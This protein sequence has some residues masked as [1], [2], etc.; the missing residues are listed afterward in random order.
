MEEREETFY[1]ITIPSTGEKFK[2]SQ[3]AYER[4]AANMFRQAP[5]AQVTRV[6][7]TSADDNDIN[8]R[9]QFQVLMDNGN[10][11]TLSAE[12]Y[13]RFKDKMWQEFPEAKVYKVSDI[14]WQRN[15]PSREEARKRLEEFDATNGEF[16]KKYEFADEQISGIDPMERSLL[17]HPQYKFWAENSSSYRA[18]QEKRNELRQA[19]YSNPNT[20]REMKEGAEVARI[21]EEDYRKKAES[22][23]GYEKKEFERA[24]KLM[25][26]V[27]KAYEA[28][29]NKDGKS[30][31]AKYWQ[32]AG[33][34]GD[35]DIWFAGARK[36]FRDLNLADIR[37][38]IE[39]LE[40][41]KGDAITETDYD[42]VITEGEKALLKS[43]AYL[44]E[45]QAERSTSDGKLAPFSTAYTAG[46][47][48][49]QSIPFMLEFLLSEGMGSAIAKGVRFLPETWAVSRGLVNSG[50]ALTRWIGKNLLSERSLLLAREAGKKIPT[51]AEAFNAGSKVGKALNLADD[52][53]VRP[54]VKG[55]WHTATQP[56]IWATYAENLNSTNDNN[57]LMGKWEAFG[58]AFW[59]NL[60]ENWSESVGSVLDKGTGWLGGKIL[61]TSGSLG[62]TSFGRFTRWMLEN[63]GTKTL[64]DAGFNGLLGEMAEEWIG[65]AVRVW[66][67]EMTGR[68]F[69]EFANWNQQLE[70]A[71]SFAPM[72]IIGLGTSTIA[73]ARRSKLYRQQAEDSK[74][75]LPKYGASDEDL[76]RI[77]NTR[78]DTPEDIAQ[79]LAPYAAKMFDAKE[80]GDKSAVE[81][82]KKLMQLSQSLGEN[83]IATQMEE[84]RKQVDRRQA[85]LEIAD[86]LGRDFVQTDEKGNKTVTRVQAPDGR[87]GY[88]VGK[89]DQSGEAA[90]LWDDGSTGFS[91]VSDDR[92]LT[93]ID[94]V[95]VSHI[96]SVQSEDEYLDGYIAEKKSAAQ[97]QR[98]EQEEKQN[99]MNLAAQLQPGAAIPMG[100]VEN[101]V[102]GT[103]IEAQADGVVVQSEDG[104]TSKISFEEAASRLGMPLRAKTDEQ[105]TAEILEA[106]DR[107][108]SK[109][110][111]LSD[112]INQGVRI[113]VIDGY[114]AVSF[115]APETQEDGSYRYPVIV[116]AANT[117]GS[118]VL[119]GRQVQSDD[120]GETGRIYLTEQEMDRLASML[121][122][123][124]KA[125][126]Y[127]EKIAA[128]TPLEVSIPNGE[129]NGS[130]TATINFT[131][132]DVEDGQ[133]MIYG[134]DAQGN[135]V[136]VTEDMVSNLPGVLA[137][138]EETPV[139][140]DE[141]VAPGEEEKMDDVNPLADYMRT[142]S[143]TGELEVDSDKLWNEN[144]DK[145]CEWNDTDNT[146]PYKVSTKDKLKYAIGELDK[147]I[148]KLAKT[149]KEGN[150]KGMEG[151]KKDELR[152]DIDALSKRR[153]ELQSLAERYQEQK[154]ETQA[155]AEANA[156]SAENTEEN[157]EK[158]MSFAERERALGDYL[159]FKD[160]VLRS[161]AMLSH[162]IMWSGSKDGV[163]KGLGSHLGFDSKSKER[164][165]RFWLLGNEK[166]AYP[167]EVAE[168]LQEAYAGEFGVA[169]EDAP[170]MGGQSALD[171]LL[172]VILENPTRTSML[173]S[174]ER[175]HREVEDKSSEYQR[176]FSAYV[177][178]LAAKYGLDAEFAADAVLGRAEDMGM[179]IEA[180][181]QEEVQ[182]MAWQ[183]SEEYLVEK[184]EYI[185]TEAARI[186]KFAEEDLEREQYDRETETTQATAGQTRQGEGAQTAATRSE[187]VVPGE[188]EVRQTSPSDGREGNVAGRDIAGQEQIYSEPASSVRESPAGAREEQ[189]EVEDLPSGEDMPEFGPFGRIFREYVGKA[190]EAI[191]ALIQNQ[192]GEAI[193]ALS[194]PQI[195]SID[196][197]WGEAGTGKSDGFGLAK[198]IKYHPEVVENLQE[199]LDDMVVVSRTENRVQL[200]SERYK[201]TVRLTWD[202]QRKTW[203]LTAFEKKNSALDNT[204]DTGETSNGSE[205]ND[206]ATPQDTVSSDKDSENSSKASESEEN[207]Q[208]LAAAL[209]RQ[210]NEIEE[211]INEKIRNRENYLGR[212][213]LYD[214][215]RRL[216]TQLEQLLG[217]LNEK[218]LADLEA[219]E[220]ESI[221]SSISEFKKKDAARRLRSR[222]SALVAKAQQFV[223]TKAKAIGSKLNLGDYLAPK[224]DA[225]VLM[226][227]VFHDGGYAV[228]SDTQILIADKASYEEKNEG[229]IIGRDG[230]PI[231]GKYPKWRELLPDF[232]AINKQW[233]DFGKLRDFIASAR[234]AIE[235][236][237]EQRKASGDTKASKAKYLKNTFAKVILNLGKNEAIAFKLDHLSNF[238]DFAERIGAKELYYSDEKRAIFVKTGKGIGMLMPVQLDWT[239][240]EASERAEF[241]SDNY[242]Y[243]YGENEYQKQG[244]A[245]ESSEEN[246]QLTAAQKNVLGWLD[247]KS[248]EQVEREYEEK[249]KAEEKALEESEKTRKK[250]E[251]RI[252]KWKKILGDVFEVH[253]DIST[254]TDK[255]AIREIEEDGSQV[256]GWYDP[257]TG[258]AH[259]YIP[260]I[261][262]DENP[263][264]RVDKT[265]LHEC[266]AHKGVRGIFKT[267]EQL[268]DFFDK[269]WKMMENY[270]WGGVPAREHFLGYV[271]G[272][273]TFATEQE[274]QRAAAD[275]F[276]AHCAEADEAVIKEM[277]SNFWT[278]LLDFIKDIFKA[279]A[280]MDIFEEEG[281]NP[282]ADII[283]QS[284]SEFVK[285]RRESEAKQREE[286][287]RQETKEDVLAA[288]D[289]E[290]TKATSTRKAQDNP[291]IAV[292]QTQE[293]YEDFGE[294]IGMARKDTAVSGIKRGDADGRPSWAKKYNTVNVR[295]LSDEEM[296]QRQRLYLGYHSKNFDEVISN[297]S[298][299][300]DFN[301]PF[302]GFWDEEKKTAFGTRTIRH[303]ITG[304]GGKPIIF[305]S[306]AQFEATMPVFE[307]SRSG[308]RVIA[309]KEGKFRIAKQASNGKYVEYAEF[310]SREDA[311]AYL[312]SPEGATD[313]LNRKRE[314]YELPALEELTRNGMPDYRN[315]KNVTP[316]D[317]Q[318]AF[319]FRGGEF[320]N[321]LNAE[322]RQQFLNYAYDALMDLASILHIS[323][324]ALSLGGE[325][326]IAFGARGKQGARAHYEPT[327]AVINLTKMNGAGS[328]AHEWAHALDNYF[329]MMD[330]RQERIRD[331]KQGDQNDHYLSRE[332]SYQ[333]GAREEVRNAFKEVMDV[334]THK[335]EVR[336]IVEEKEREQ[337]DKRRNW[338]KREVEYVR[339][340]LEMGRT[341]YEY[342][343]KTKQ[344]E[345]VK[346][347]MTEEQLAEFDSLVARLETD[348]T[349]KYDW[350]YTR[351]Q[352]RGQGEVADK[353]RELIKE[354]MPDRKADNP[355][356]D[357][358]H[359]IALTRKQ[360]ERL[361][362]AKDG[363]TETLRVKTDM[364][365]SSEWFDRGRAGSY[366]AKPLEM[367]ARAFET[368][369]AGEMKAGVQT[370]D[371]LTYEKSPLYMA[372]W[373]KSPYPMGAER[374]AAK[375]AFDK[376]FQTIQEK[377][378]EKTGRQVL[379]SRKTVTIPSTSEKKRITGTID[380]VLAFVQG[381]SVKEA[382]EFRLAEE[383]KRKE[384]AAEIYGR[385]LNNQFDSVTLR[386]IN[387]YIDNGTPKNPYGRRISKRL[388]QEVERG[389]YEGAR[390][391]A[392]DALLSRISEGAV[393]P[394]RRNSPSERRRIAQA[395]NVA[396]KGWAIAAGNW[397]TDLKQFTDQDKPFASGSDS[398]V[399]VSKEGQYVI[400]ASHGKSSAKK[401]APDIDNI[402]LFN[403]I[404]PNTAYEILG[405]GEIDGKFVRILKQPVVEYDADNKL[406]VDERVQY[407]HELGFEPIN[408]EKTVFS[409][410]NLV[411][412]DLQKSNIVYDKAGNV[413]VIDADVKLHTKD[414]GGEYT[415]PPVEDDLPSNTLF[416]RRVS[417]RHDAEYLAAVEAGDMEKA[418]RMVNAAAR[419]A[420]YDSGSGYQGSI[421]FN[422]AA[423]SRNGYFDTREERKE[424]FDNGEFEDTYSLGDFME[425]GIDNND[426]QWKLDNPIPAIARDKAT[427]ESIHNLHDAVNA[428]A[429]TI[430][431][432]R[433]VPSD[434]KEGSFRNGDW[435]TPSRLY[436]QNHIE[437]QE[438][439]GGRIIEREVPVDDIW[440]NGDDINEWGYD[441]G[442][443]YA[444]ANTENNRKELAPVTYDDNG[445]II[446]LSKRFDSSKSDTRFSRVYHG[447]G[448]DFERFDH[449]HMGEG[450]GSQVYG[451]GTYVSTNR[452]TGLA[453]ARSVGGSDDQYERA[454]RSIENQRIFISNAEA[455]L[456]RI[457]MDKATPQ[458]W[459]A[460]LQ[461]EGGLK[462]GEDKW[463][464]L[465]DWL[466]A[467]NKKTITKQEVADFIAK[468]QI[469][470]EEEHYSEDSNL[471]ENEKMLELRDEFY[472]LVEE[473]DEA[474]G[475]IYVSDHADWAFRQMV[476]RYGDDFEKG[477]EWTYDENRYPKLVAIEDIY[478]GGISEAAR[479][480]LGIYD[481]PIE[482]TRLD[483][484]TEGLSNKREI[485]LTVPKVESYSPGDIEHFGDAGEGRAVAWIRFGEANVG[486]NKRALVIDEI[487]SK[488]HQDGREFGYKGDARVDEARKVLQSLMDK[489]E[490]KTMRD[491]EAS[492]TNKTDHD[493]FTKN[494]LIVAKVVPNA[495]FEKN[496]HELA[497][498]RML[499][500]AAEEGYDFVAWTTG[501]QQAERYNIGGVV[502]SIERRESNNVGEMEFTINLN[503]NAGS[504]YLTTD[505]E[506]NVI[507]TI[508]DDFRDKNLSDIVG[509]E[510]AQKMLG[511]KENESISGDG[512]RVGGEGMKGFYDQMLPSFMNKYGKKWGVKV[513]D[514]TL[515]DLG[516]GPMTVHSVQVTPEMKESVMPGQVMFSRKF[517]PEEIAE[518]ET[519]ILESKGTFK[520]LSEAEKWAKK[521]LQGK[522]YTNKF[523]GESVYIGNKSVSEMLD[524]ESAKKIDIEL[525]KA[526][527]MS[528]PE[529]ITDGIPAE[530]HPDTHGRDFNVMRLYSAIKLNDDIYRVK[531][532]VKRVKQGDK[533][534][535]Y[536][537]QE[538]ELTEERPQTGEGEE[539]RS[540]NPN[541]SI[542]SISG[543]KL[544]KGVK[545]TNSSE[546]ILPENGN[547]LFSRTPANSKTVVEKVSDGGIGAFVGKDNVRDLLDGI[548]RSMP[549]TMRREIVFRAM[550]GDL[551][552]HTALKGYLAELAEKGF[553]NDETGLLRAAADM[554]NGYSEEGAVADDATKRYLV[555]KLGQDGRSDILERISDIA[556]RNRWGVGREQKEESSVQFSLKD[557][558]ESKAAAAEKSV[559]A[560][561]ESL[562]EQKKVLKG[563]LLTAAMAMASQKEY[564]QA[565]VETVTR[566]AKDLLK[567]QG[568]DGAS[569]F[570]VGRILGIINSSVG[571]SPAIVRR[572]CNA[573]LDIIIDRILKNERAALDKLTSIKATKTNTTGVEVQGALDLQGQTTVKAF[574][575]GLRME[576]GKSDDDASKGT[577]LGRMS[578]LSDRLSSEDDAVRNDAVAEY[579]GLQL[580][581]EYLENIQQS[582]SEED[583]LENELKDAQEMRRTKRMTPKEYAEFAAEV[584]HAIREN[585][586]ARIE[587][588]REMQLKMQDIISGSRGK[589]VEFREKEQARI[590][591]IHH[592]ANSDMEGKSASPFQKSTFLG[593]L[594]N[595]S[596]V[597]FFT[598]SLASFDQMLRLFGRKN[599]RGE[600]YLWNKFMRGWE[601]A[602][603]NAYLGR[604]EAT[605]K[606]DAKVSEVFGRKMRWS[607]LYEVERKMPKATATWWDGGEMK[608]H[609]LTQGNLLYIYMVN[610]MSDG[611][612]KLRRMGIKEEDV[613]AIVEQMDE[614]FIELADWMQE[615]FLVELRNKYN[616]VHERVFGAS[617]A[618]IED[619]FPLKI[620]KRS[621][622]KSEDVGRPDMDDLLPATTTGSIIKRRRN[623]QDLDIPGADAFSVIIEHIDQMEQWAAFAEY[624]KDINTLLSYTRFRN[625]VK[626]TDSIYGTGDQLWAKFKN[627]ARISTGTYHPSVKVESLDTAAVNV[628]KGVTMAKISFRVYTALKQLLSMPAFVSDA[629]LGYLLKN[630][631]NPS[632]AWNWAMENLPLVEKRWKSRQAG[633]TRL[634]QTDSD[635]KL[636]RSKVVETAGRIGMTPN[637]FVDAVTVSIGAYAMYQT[638]Y[639]QYIKD[640][641]PEEQADKRA[642][643]DATILY[644]ETQQSN[645][646]AFLSDVQLDRTVLSTMITVFRNS[647]MG[648]QRQLHDA[649]RGL[650][651]LMT[652]GYKE[653][654]INFMTKQMMRDGMTEEQAQHA[655]EREFGRSAVR[656]SVRVATFGFLVQFYWNLGSHIVYLLFGDDDDKKKEMLTEDAIHA[657]LGGNVEG[658]AGG[659]IASEM[660]N[661]L[662]KG[663]GLNNYDPTLLPLF[664]D[665]KNLIKKMDYDPVAG[666][667]DLVNLAIQIGIGVNPQ[668]ITD[669]IVALVDAAGGNM[670]TSKEA[671]MFAFRVMQVP[672][673]QLDEMLIDELGI[674][675]DSK[676]DMDYWDIAERYATYKTMRNAPITGWLYSDEA[677]NKREQA[678]L[679]SFRKKV[680]ARK[681]LIDKED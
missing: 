48:F 522:S 89:P 559:E 19:Y 118:T 156:T 170:G 593:R 319:G 163:H 398:D 407:M 329:G 337:L 622:N 62:K 79:K 186:A 594:A 581:K 520:N 41:E 55:L 342:N 616:E 608:E 120:N 676:K 614:R 14:S 381:T 213:Q 111:T 161:L 639:N 237:Y 180:Y 625:Q 609:E 53:V 268:N 131:R 67:G 76:K 173:E 524:E 610:K 535:T 159:N 498:K 185:A 208:A 80:A 477:F 611:R 660:L 630:M 279:S 138:A 2:V 413:A 531:S 409:N 415:Y 135:E 306:Q 525:H 160:F 311:V 454:I 585:R 230:K 47:G 223:R 556:L 310:D 361:Q 485:A 151:K 66:S 561:K 155:P 493:T 301:Q 589:A 124:E 34:I 481:K 129:E 446:P 453:Y 523:T 422:G 495:P 227:G 20:V 176:E 668:T 236:E 4:N 592:L 334:L 45:I 621:L 583:G 598:S 51:A 445:D 440:W 146:D 147:K 414:V 356:H 619:Y 547:T 667:N 541:S 231:E 244:A 49:A 518:M 3:Q 214:Q 90:V 439:N 627:V 5:D 396:L 424:A 565:T 239:R 192:G 7:L 314:N 150:L 656:N 273:G 358:F 100:T 569:R 551:N 64:A 241:F 678:Y 251:D 620:N 642:K 39:K 351:Q 99:S 380:K 568:M 612:M 618:A 427:L 198:I 332:R 572:N 26:D 587:A 494:K 355:L 360:A 269:V 429:K 88:V 580:A 6:T 196:I 98:K 114:E 467:S 435:I 16:M 317:F 466:N 294:K 641:Y 157:N 489:Y 341:T 374:V 220:D 284:L 571:K 552:I 262:K 212:R 602:S 179:T 474:T 91:F 491:L 649:L 545:K 675:P 357:L 261:L 362:A 516:D 437:L 596:L 470:I 576:I 283:R 480:Y 249:R 288:I 416:S 503:D 368:Y 419:E 322:E 259:L 209:V 330:A 152:R 175:M 302:V 473:G 479:Y 661:L 420:G 514:I 465:S 121:P 340:R 132:A 312:S 434:V 447:T 280:G 295:M 167:D 386:L 600:G 631:A 637:A 199:I 233:M 636:W 418:Q 464:G 30:E 141:N 165:T 326:S 624:N 110:R 521:N 562:D 255:Q 455:A 643:Q 500:L 95:P 15:E 536:E 586:I 658:L 215:K 253:T 336:A 557:E 104:S 69:A 632:A 82:Y 331:E 265:I 242:V 519:P 291:Q 345:E 78:F 379:F 50:S 137:K 1:D 425:A 63:Q 674:N 651:R 229:K 645:E 387:E 582:E 325:L 511:L 623:A 105:I 655:A 103:V 18:L 194:H 188:Q 364:L 605:E 287:A 603:E 540:H 56:R 172:E 507:T 92:A 177:E 276:V 323:P 116:K 297:I 673:S 497:M 250:V 395:K 408:K 385:V 139:K 316:D 373:G 405:Y 634:M 57:E 389:L 377:T 217:G 335:M 210:I 81:D 665:M 650:G 338:L 528:V 201:A 278:R 204:T 646:G 327:R 423:P 499:R 206:T 382:K 42:S 570:E 539:Q 219:S 653:Q 96:T 448:A 506:G 75:W 54:L 60:I 607:D 412:A 23:V 37:K 298:K 228:A 140:A 402:P 87:T 444:Y 635:W 112:S 193:G 432:Y 238:A 579:T 378:D 202:E 615:E 74:K 58:H 566:L 97:Q 597:R 8:D 515:Y 426:L 130:D 549:E 659:N 333:K 399:Y 393:P 457:K 224:G 590:Q 417:S 248:P 24:A 266:L 240:G 218:A 324:K 320:G 197:V 383:E 40:K 12:K 22:A 406:S 86:K 534:Y 451:W 119:P 461:K 300:T 286:Q 128:G 348:S 560:A 277:D 203:L 275:E 436:A 613:Q 681:E 490:A 232:E 308:F 52:V 85:G 626:N 488:R 270:T 84:Y 441:D 567:E 296:A 191:Q 148:E 527:L 577:I 530:I 187:G 513:E 352:W 669:A 459:I 633:D 647:S 553:E 363:K 475:S 366:F 83:Q 403:Y 339:T 543:A 604:K 205:R 573:L 162:R 664:S 258:K 401:F 252:A 222:I 542:N 671:L 367:F 133:I 679:K 502:S 349:F 376:L 234:A 595:S 430:K 189:G 644:N 17:S 496:W 113:Q 142:N 293:K 102:R 46:Q 370:S 501:D 554:I 126:R 207:P 512:L 43:A 404:F 35:L 33:V 460:M 38:K 666:V 143:V 537:L 463:L 72:S 628:A 281:A 225:R 546:T 438:W 662:A 153:A 482:S 469:Q 584:D 127:N 106:E 158:N 307:A 184:D 245:P 164:K 343:R 384:A 28:P 168:S 70:M 640:G 211:Q 346:H 462:V 125:G 292:S 575:A 256:N 468:N 274:A 472:E 486:L 65:N 606:L 505:K 400:K 305:Q 328:L 115:L 428:K 391:N 442:K 304:E 267:E 670:D 510:V 309:Y 299:G 108:V 21:M 117:E 318:S 36:M 390:T 122:V 526:A 354:I 563:K 221:R 123:G 677:E 260:H 25:S 32:G 680:K 517:S 359:Q 353:I 638:R 369:V 344:R 347:T 107:A 321:W 171:T 411:V 532:T 657:L 272:T 456:G 145:W 27:A 290:E 476:E 574:H 431:M 433:A 504:Q 654:S 235:K 29:D 166:G 487:Q 484:T 533:Y 181:L 9:D 109:K 226:T 588:Y 599:V 144:P 263:L 282:F 31:L 11:E 134:T 303:Y 271:G 629:N 93:S 564:D 61:G 449:S 443:G 315:G 94:G 182:W 478:A 392:V 59:D 652:K 492:I 247:G 375:E 371:Y 246:V 68:E 555:W 397:Y 538:M 421:A 483:Y 195:G 10:Y 101:P 243:S 591:S 663:D 548:Y 13:S 254:V 529:F 183:E 216:E 508:V 578:A 169:A 452:E 136:S 190:K 550:E 450:E 313:L 372:A 178:E 71:A 471:D 458:Q 617:M 350:D 257:A 365:E 558:L 264:S 544:L 509:K 200:E 648:Y 285:A 154:A 410:K 77:F 44:A 394:S 672:Q 73:A 289:G 601:E 174:A 149:L 388:P